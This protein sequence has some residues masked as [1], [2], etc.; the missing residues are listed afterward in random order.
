MPTDTIDML[1]DLSDL[2]PTPF[3]Q[4][5]LRNAKISRDNER[6]ERVRVRR[7]N[8][9]KGFAAP[10]I[11]Q[12]YHVQLDSS[13]TRRSRSGTRFEKNTRISVE[14]VSD[15]DYAA[16]K[17]KNA[18]A[19]VVTVLGAEYILEDDA[20]HVFEAPDPGHDSEVLRQRNADL[21]AEAAVIR[22][23]NARLRA[24]LAERSARMNAPESTDGRPTR[25]PAA[26]AARASAT[27]AKPAANAPTTPAADFGA[28][29]TTEPEKK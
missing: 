27:T 7:A 20:L 26:Q 17:A 4:E 5:Q 15:E 16:A 10:R 13:I 9:A 22:E 25:I 1:D 18:A 14:V 3:E 6:R 2:P 11:G 19:P 24:Q 23:D 8:Q 12:T 21:E 29:A 28:P